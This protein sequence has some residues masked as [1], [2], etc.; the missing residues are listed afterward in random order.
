MNN[1]IKKN[2]KATLPRFVVRFLQQR[3]GWPIVGTLLME[4]VTKKIKSQ[5]YAD[6]YPVVHNCENIVIYMADGKE[7]HGGL[8]DRLRGMLSVYKTCKENDVKFCIYHDHPF[9]LENYLLPNEYDWRIKKSNISYNA[10][11][12]SPFFIEI[13]PVLLE[14]AI[15]KAVAR[16]K[17]SNKQ[18]HIYANA[19]Y[20][21]Q[22]DYSGL[23]KELFKPSAALQKEI[24]YHYGKLSAKEGY[25]SLTFRFQNLMGDF[26]ER[27]EAA[28][29][30]L[31]LSERVALM[32]KCLNEI[33]RM[34][35]FY[36]DCNQFLVTSDSVSFLKEAGKIDFVYVIPGEI[37]HCAN[38]NDSDFNLHLKPFVDFFMISK[39]DKGFLLCTDN[40]Y[41]SGF[42]KNATLVNNVPFEIIYF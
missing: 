39:A 38:T 12:S 22:K 18:L 8:A 34:K 27:I 19:N 30:I 21:M 29:L 11:Q 7:A 33:Y 41:R 37:I 13:T 23:F 3:W 25:I 6:T 5:H 36:S 1:K 14:Q 24:D 16:I 10:H 32:K 20:A 2:L 26:N 15:N 31:S 40:M 17:T 35:E 9:I 42:P 4:K 28:P